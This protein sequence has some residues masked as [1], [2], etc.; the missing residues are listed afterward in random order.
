MALLASVVGWYG[1]WLV[2]GRGWRLWADRDPRAARVLRRSGLLAVA[3]PV[4]FEAC[5]ARCPALG[6]WFGA[7][8]W[9]V[10]LCAGLLFLFCLAAL[11]PEHCLRR[12][13][14]IYVGVW[15]GWSAC[16]FSGPLLLGHGPFRLAATPSDGAK[17][18]STWWSCGPAAAASLSARLGRPISERRAAASCRTWPMLG[19]FPA[20]MAGGMARAGFRTRVRW[21]GRHAH[22]RPGR[23]GLAYV[24]VLKYLVH[25]TAVTEVTADRVT[26]FDPFLGPMEMSRA[27][28]ERKWLGVFVEVKP[29]K[30]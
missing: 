2:V 22:L 9:Q 30:E 29:R 8:E 14:L 27:E 13:L 19:T 25:I 3:W 24:V 7:F 21:L 10:P 11:A 1:L 6:A 16:V 20:A 15:L 23:T 4:L 17:T 5:G 18:Q 26:L 28:F 12:P